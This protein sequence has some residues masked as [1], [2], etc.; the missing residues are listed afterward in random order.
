VKIIIVDDHG[1]VRDGIRWMLINEPS[2]EV[3]GEAADGAALME[4]LTTITPDLV[5]LDVRMPGM[6]GLETLKAIRKRSPD[7]PV[8][9]LSMHDEPEL[10]AAAIERG[11]D[12]YMLKSA[13]RDELIRAIGKVGGGASYLQGDLTQPL[14]ARMTSAQ[15][16]SVPELSGPDRQILELAAR[17]LGNEE[18]ARRVDVSTPRVKAALQRICEALGAHG[19]S[20]AV[21]IA[22]RLDLID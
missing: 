2:I 16:R 9:M 4:M 8:L 7:L 10:V 19:R 18:I 3:V 17:G 12:G 22:L 11:A 6:S 13:D 20:E 14:V 1:I 21:A 15:S 5:L